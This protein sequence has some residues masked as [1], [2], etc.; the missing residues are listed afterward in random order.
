MA[1]DEHTRCPNCGG[2]LFHAVPGETTANEIVAFKKEVT[3]RRG[4]VFEEMDWI[5][6]GS[7]CYDCD[8]GVLVEYPPPNLQHVIE[9]NRE[10]VLVL[11][12][13]GADIKAVAAILKDVLQITSKEAIAFARADSGVIARRPSARMWQ[14]KAFEA[15]IMKAGATVHLE[16]VG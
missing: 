14:L 8:W 12:S 13:S 4:V 9:D 5:H 2:E 1:F 6:P 11:D 15:A 7:F 3:R 10:A 16:R